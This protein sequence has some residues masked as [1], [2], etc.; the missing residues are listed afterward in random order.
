MIVLR[1]PSPLLGGAAWPSP[2][3]G[4]AA[5]LPPSLGVLLLSPRAAWPPPLLLVLP[6]TPSFGLCC[7]SF[8]IDHGSFC[9]VCRVTMCVLRI[10]PRPLEFYGSS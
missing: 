9:C 1:S 4:G 3:S 10:V 2:S 5:F 7:R 6:S 8:F